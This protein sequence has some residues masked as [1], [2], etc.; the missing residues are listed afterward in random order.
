MVYQCPPELGDLYTQ[1]EKM[2]VK[3]Q[4]QQSAAI[5]AKAKQDRISA[6]TRRKRINRIRC[7]AWKYGLTLFGILYLSWI[8]WAVVEIR[9]EVYPE[10]GVCLIPKGSFMY[11][12]YNN[13]KWVDCEPR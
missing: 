12:Q 3:M 6:A 9:K 5:A 13:L 7:E 8:I 2:M 4:K 1:V 10:L 11:E